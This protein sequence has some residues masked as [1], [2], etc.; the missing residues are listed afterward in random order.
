MSRVRI[1]LQGEFATLKSG[2]RV[3]L[4]AVYKPTDLIP[5]M[6]AAKQL[7]VRSR[8]GEQWSELYYEALCQAPDGVTKRFSCWDIDLD[9]LRSDGLPPWR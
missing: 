5:L 2:L 1:P 7:H 9:D 4:V 3:L 6:D 8:L